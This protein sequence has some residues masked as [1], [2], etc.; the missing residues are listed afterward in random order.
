MPLHQQNLPGPLS[1]VAIIGPGLIGGSLALALR[2]RNPETALRLWARS[3]SSV[4]R[5][6]TVFPE[7]TADLAAAVRSASLCV[8]CTPIGSMPALAE[9]MAPHLPADAVVTDA[10]SAKGAL[11]RHLEGILGDRF[12][13][14]HPMAGS[15]KSGL[16]AARADLFDGAVCIL[17]PTET[18]RPDALRRTRDLWQSV[19][20]RTVEMA[21]DA[22]D[23]AIARI[24][25]L[26]HAVAAALVNAVSRGRPGAETL[27]GGGYRDT[28][29]IAASSPALWKEIFLENKES[30]LAGL[31]DFTATLAD[32]KRMILAHDAPALE[33]FLTRA[34]DARN[35]LP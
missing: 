12:V 13:G 16:D 17:T 29:R 6:K 26:P 2:Q 19:G 21:P 8:L 22:H 18:T 34:Q 5:A 30:L 31:D 14:S 9:R 10:G 27:A 23:E 25:H 7:V 24:S 20:C 35:R 4:S 1:T 3:A 33:D 15:E 32:F 28:T 11:V